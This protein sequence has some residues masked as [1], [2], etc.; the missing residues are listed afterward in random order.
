MNE[1][2]ATVTW[3]AEDIMAIRPEMS[4]ED[5]EEFL[6]WNEDTIEEMMVARGWE[7]IET[8]LS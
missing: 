8:L 6:V 4:K 5:A 3:V 7:A 1:T 2:Y